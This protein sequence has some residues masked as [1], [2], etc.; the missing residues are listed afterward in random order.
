M[1]TF[2][3]QF[4]DLFVPWI[5]QAATQNWDWMWRGSRRQHQNFMALR[6]PW[7]KSPLSPCFTG[8]RRQYRLH[9]YICIYI[10]IYMI[11]YVHI[12]TFIFL[13]I[14]ILYFIGHSQHVNIEFIC[15]SVL[16][17]ASRSPGPCWEGSVAEI[18][19]IWKWV[20]IYGGLHKNRES[21]KWLV[22]NGQ[23][24]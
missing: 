19:S 20:T 17:V 7:P 14:Y 1:V 10:Y 4:L 16:S 15:H 18:A 6:N 5:P 9:V 3:S 24:Y 23:F 13:Y 12:Y 8:H 2:L 22:Y 11:I 21:P